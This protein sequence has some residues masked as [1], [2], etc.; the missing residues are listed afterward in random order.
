MEPRAVYGVFR[1]ESRVPSAKQ[2]RLRGAELANMAQPRTVEAHEGLFAPSSTCLQLLEFF[3]SWRSEH[4]PGRQ[5][6]ITPH[7]NQYRS[8]EGPL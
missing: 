4:S 6:A 7:P 5:Q 3:P 1:S 2:P 8:G